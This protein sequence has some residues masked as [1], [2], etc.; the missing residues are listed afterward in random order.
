MVCSD[1]TKGLRG[2]PEQGVD[3]V[4]HSLNPQNVV[5]HTTLHFTTKDG[6]RAAAGEPLREGIILPLIHVGLVLV[7]IM[8]D[9][10]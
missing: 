6:S 1:R 3:S 2:T 4:N 7:M 10:A 9:L 8:C 5:P